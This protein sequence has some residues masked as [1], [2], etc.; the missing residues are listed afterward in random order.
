PCLG[1]GGVGQFAGPAE[2]EAFPFAQDLPQGHSQPAGGGSLAGSAVGYDDDATHGWRYS[3]CWVGPGVR[4]PG[5]V[6]CLVGVGGDG[7]GDLSALADFAE[8]LQEG[9]DRSDIGNAH[10]GDGLAL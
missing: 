9:I 6:G 4:P 10:A 3:L 2:P 5:S 8:T 7:L 1:G